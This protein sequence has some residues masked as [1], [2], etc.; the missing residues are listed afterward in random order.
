M[1][2]DS[3]SHQT[4]SGVGVAGVGASAAVAGGAQPQVDANSVLPA[5]VAGRAAF[6]AEAVVFRRTRTKLDRGCAASAGWPG[7]RRRHGHIRQTEFKEICCVSFLKMPR[8][9][10]YY[11]YNEELDFP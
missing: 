1:N 4:L 10:T 8:S 9:N 2:E 11:N 5:C 6:A 3:V 7:D